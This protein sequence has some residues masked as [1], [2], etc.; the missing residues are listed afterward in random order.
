[1]PRNRR[2]LDLLAIDRRNLPARRIE[3]DAGIFD[4]DRRRCGWSRKGCGG[5]KCEEHEIL[6]QGQLPPLQPP[7]GA[8]NPRRLL[9]PAIALDCAHE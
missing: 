7:V 2:T 3:R 8:S 4:E 1:M 9:R 5:E 6:A